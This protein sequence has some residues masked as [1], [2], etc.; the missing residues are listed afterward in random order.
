MK[1]ILVTCDSDFDKFTPN[2]IGRSIIYLKPFPTTNSK[3]LLPLIKGQFS[4]LDETKLEGQLI[5]IGSERIEY[6]NL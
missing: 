3:Y 1:R 2:D 6:R 5:T 4:N